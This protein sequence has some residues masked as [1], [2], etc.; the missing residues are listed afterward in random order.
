[1]QIC[2][3]NLIFKVEIISEVEELRWEGINQTTL[4]DH[5][6]YVRKMGEK[7]NESGND[8]GKRE[9]KEETK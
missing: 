9:K 4:Q 5:E 6:K 8:K 2:L 1:M 7:K 3:E